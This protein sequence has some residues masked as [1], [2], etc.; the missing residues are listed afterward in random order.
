MTGWL[1]FGGS[2]LMNLFL[3]SLWLRDRKGL[4]ER[5]DALRAACLAADEAIKEADEREAAAE[6]VYQSA[7][8]TYDHLSAYVDEIGVVEKERG[9]RVHSQRWVEARKKLAIFERSSQVH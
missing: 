4:V 6:Y 7:Q 1:L 5:H 2:V 8:D 9:C 3:A